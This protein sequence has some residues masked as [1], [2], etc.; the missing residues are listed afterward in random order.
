MSDRYAWE[1]KAKSLAKEN[2]SLTTQLAERDA[3]IERLRGALEPFADVGH[4]LDEFTEPS[5]GFGFRR[6][7]VPEGNVTWRDITEADYEKAKQALTK[8]D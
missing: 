7:T 2:E 5:H 3:E 8:G 1:R 4:S 6:L